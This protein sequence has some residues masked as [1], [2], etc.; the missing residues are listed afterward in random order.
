ML[1]IEQ[2]R[3]K[4]N[5]IDAAIIKKL[6]ERQKFSK[7]IGKLK[8]IS[9]KSVID[10]EREKELIDYHENLSAK[11]HLQEKFVKR[12]F[13]IIIGYSRGL[14]K[15]K[16]SESSIFLQ[17]SPTVL[18]NSIAAEKVA[19][20]IKVFNLSAG[21]PILQPHNLVIQAVTNALAQGE[22]LY[23]PVMGISKLRD[24]SSNWM[25]NEYGCNY[26]SE[27]TLVVNGGKFGIYLLLQLFLKKGD[28]VIITS[29]YWVSYPAITKLFGGVP[30]IIETNEA[31]GWKFKPED[32]TKVYTAKSKILILNNGCNPTGSL[33]TKK[34]LAAILEVAKT[35]NLLVISDEVYSGLTYD[36]KTYVSCGSFPNYQHHVV[37]VQSCS[38]SFSMTGWRIGFVFGAK[39]IISKLTSLISQSTSGV[40]TLSQWAAIAAFKQAKIINGWIREEMQNRRN[41][42]IKSLKDNFDITISSPSSA[43]YIFI[44]LKSL[45]IN[46]INSAQFCER[47]LAYANVALVPGSAFGREGYVRISFGAQPTDLLLGIK[48]LANFCKTIEKK[49]L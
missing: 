16:Y 25:N 24:L 6:A 9:G 5:K 18:I 42:L 30:I 22:T 29:P 46:N 45:G 10:I 8:D 36:D 48:A 1:T 26:Q 43:L 38:K 28:E 23:P 13:R 39:D 2:L 15:P 17:D 33:Y 3:K 40:T 14:Q 12:L 47:A 32:L 4:I 37:V 11:Y 44:S 31:K 20:G 35:L 27:N 41:V 19:S 34:E 49:I 7:Q 21:E